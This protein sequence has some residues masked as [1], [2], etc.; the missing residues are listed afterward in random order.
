MRTTRKRRNDGLLLPSLLTRERFGW[1]LVA[2]SGWVLFQL[3]WGYIV[4]PLIANMF[5]F[6]LKTSA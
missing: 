5:L 6:K 2:I 3:Q 4:K 1:N